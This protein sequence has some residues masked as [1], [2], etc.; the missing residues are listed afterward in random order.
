ML[1]SCICSAEG[2][3]K[4]RRFLRCWYIEEV[5]VLVAEET[6]GERDRERRGE[7][8]GINPLVGAVYLRPMNV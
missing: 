8:R 1:I 2:R 7:V 3:N 5:N 4:T 6:D